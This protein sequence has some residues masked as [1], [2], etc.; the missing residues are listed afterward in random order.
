MPS[1]VPEMVKELTLAYFSAFAYPRNVDYMKVLGMKASDLLAAADRVGDQVRL[2]VK[3]LFDVNVP[4]TN[5]GGKVGGI[6][7]PPVFPTPFFED[8]G[9]FSF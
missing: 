9:D 4:P 1:P 6:G 5:V 2:A 8:L 7:N 3:R